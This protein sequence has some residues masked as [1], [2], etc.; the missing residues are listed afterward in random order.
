MPSTPKSYIEQV[1]HV[2]FKENDCVEYE[3]KRGRIYEFHTEYKLVLLGG[4][5]RHPTWVPIAD[6][7]FVDRTN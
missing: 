7:T 1:N 4:L 2:G 5:Q 6:I 3:G